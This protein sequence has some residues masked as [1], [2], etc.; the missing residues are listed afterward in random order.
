[1]SAASLHLMMPSRLC[2]R[3]WPDA[4]SVSGR[5]CCWPAAGNPR[6]KIIVMSFDLIL[7]LLAQDP[8]PLGFGSMLPALAAIMALFYF[9]LIRP[10]RRKQRSHQTMLSSL[11]KNDRVVTV[12]GIH[13]TVTNVNRDADEVV[14]KIDEATNTKIRVTISSITR[15]TSDDS[16]KD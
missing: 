11:K 10:E 16:D 13:A 6:W 2:F 5:F 8:E 15:I 4:P 1:M 7:P 14:L 9:M 12:G 3:F